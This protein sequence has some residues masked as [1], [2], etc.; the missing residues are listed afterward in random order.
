VTVSTPIPSVSSTDLA[1]DVTIRVFGQHT[2][3]RAARIDAANVTGTVFSS[4]YTQYSQ[5]FVDAADTSAATTRWGPAVPGDGAAYQTAG[6]WAASFASTRYLTFSFPAYVPGGGVVT[7]ASIDHSYKSATSGDTSCWYME[8]YNSSTLLATKGSTGTPLSCNSTT[9]FVTDTVSIPE[10]NNP[11]KAN[12]VVIRIYARNSGSRR[13]DHDLV[14]L[15]LIYS[16]PSV[17]SSDVTPPAGADIQTAN[18]SGGTA[19][20]AEIGDQVTY[21]F[22]EA[23][24][25][26]SLITGWD[27]TSRNVIA[28]ILDGGTGDDT[29]YVWDPV[30]SANA[31]FGSVDLNG[32]FV[33]S[34][35]VFGSSG[36]PST[37]VMSGSAITVTLGTLSS[38]TALTDSTTT[39]MAWTPSAAATDLAGNPCSTGVVNESGAA[40]AGF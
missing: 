37:I 29:L 33:S 26:A 13:T 23:M 20:R 12:N 7:G 4:P 25:P 18:A 2:S 19:G 24:D 16:L 39:P 3:N 14:R 15:N 38:G 22:T 6:N 34:T 8:V 32:D 35:V 5:I 1:N 36:T 28:Y 10:V 21:T 27:G 17:G 30:L 40:D 31:N 11:N 9:S